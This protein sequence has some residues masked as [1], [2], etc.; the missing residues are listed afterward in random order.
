MRDLEVHGESRISRLSLMGIAIRRRI[1][2]DMVEGERERIRGVLEGEGTFYPQPSSRA[3]WLL[4]INPPPRS[5]EIR[6]R[7]HDF[8]VA[9]SAG[10]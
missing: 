3:T 1:I 10:R 9:I 4:T 2:N 8:G 5:H 7:L 6:P